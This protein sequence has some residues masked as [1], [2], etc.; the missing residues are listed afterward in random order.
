MRS[1][2]FVQRTTRLLTFWPPKPAPIVVFLTRRSRR[3][4]CRARFGN[5][6]Q[7][8]VRAVQHAAMHLE[9][10]VVG[11]ERAGDDLRVRPRRLPGRVRAP[12]PA[13]G[14]RLLR[15]RRHRILR[16]DGDDRRC[17]GRARAADGA[18]VADGQMRRR[19]RSRA[20][21]AMNPVARHAGPPRDADKVLRLED[22]TRAL[23]TR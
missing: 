12:R 11:L 2:R 10:A 20:T 4:P 19:S 17:A 9:D 3:S 8:G 15:R 18:N 7:H 1:P 13:A 14:S 5:L 16:G 22:Y 21:T 6:E 23:G